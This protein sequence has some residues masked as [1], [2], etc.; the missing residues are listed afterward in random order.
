MACGTRVIWLMANIW[1]YGDTSTPVFHP[2]TRVD[3][4]R[5]SGLK[6][7]F[8]LQAI[9]GNAKVKRAWRGSN[10]GG[11]T[12]SAVTEYGGYASTDPS[13]N[14]GANAQTPDASYGLVEFGMTGVNSTGTARGNCFVRVRVD[15]I[16]Q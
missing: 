3:P 11:I 8:E 7:S 14:E 1:T 13:W 5:V 15:I 16:N 10:D 12:W 2:L 6:Q 4:S 9:T